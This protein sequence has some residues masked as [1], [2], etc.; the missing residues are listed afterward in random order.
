M[1][2]MLSLA[3]L[4][5]IYATMIVPDNYKTIQDAVNNAAIGDNIIVNEGIYRENIVI[6]KPVTI[7]SRKGQDFTTVSAAVSSEPVFKV[8]NVDNFEITGFTATGSNK[9]GIYINHSNHG[10]L[11]DNK[12]EKNGNG[13]ALYDSSNNRLIGNSAVSNQ[14]YGIY[15]EASHRNALE[16]N[17]AS[18][19]RDN[20]IFLS[21]SNYNQVTGNNAIN[22]TWNGILLWDSSYN[23]ISE[24]KVWRNRFGI[25]ISEGSNNALSNNSTWSNL[26]II[27]PLILAY[28][29]II[30]YII[31]RRLLQFIYRV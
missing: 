23:T 12:T 6:T 3:G 10:T 16:Q 26:Y 29:G 18:L 20:G 1:R 17:I 25:V 27:M 14:S 2:H 4:A 13:I 24:N 9:S 22:N 11:S 28:I 15:I 30:S 8:S 21:S 7:K 31:Q 19:N 5:L